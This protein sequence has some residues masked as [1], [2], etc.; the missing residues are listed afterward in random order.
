MGKILVLE[1]TFS[2]CLK[3]SPPFQ[4]GTARPRAVMPKSHPGDTEEEWSGEGPPS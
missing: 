3:Q 4:I 2:G 1:E